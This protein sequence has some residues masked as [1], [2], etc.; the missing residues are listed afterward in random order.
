MSILTKLKKLLKKKNEEKDEKEQVE[1]EETEEKEESVT[2][3]LENLRNESVLDDT[4]NAIKSWTDTLEAAKQ[5]PLSQAKIVN[6]KILEELSYVLNQMNLKM[7]KL[8]KLE[9]LEKL[10]KLDEILSILNETK[11]EL[12]EKGVKS[13]NLEKA[14]GEIENLTIK[15]KE[16]ISWIEKQGKVTANQLAKHLDLS[17]STASFR[18]NRLAEMDILKKEA[19]GKRIYYTVK[20]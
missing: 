7:N 6:T 3:N 20:I 12:D 11:E 15:D 9:K 5:H 1:E 19:S 4:E 13:E 14:I 10:D 2:L 17:R 8:E 16:V 18:L